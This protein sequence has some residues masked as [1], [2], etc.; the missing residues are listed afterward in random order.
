[1]A[2]SYLIN[3]QTVSSTSTLHKILLGIA[4]LRSIEECMNAS[5]YEA[6]HSS[7][8]QIIELASAVAHKFENIRTPTFDQTDRKHQSFA[9]AAAAA[10]RALSFMLIKAIL[11][12]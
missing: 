10:G 6:N 7:R 5:F 8:W 4:S 11:H 1:M 2:V 3:I 9:G 12:M